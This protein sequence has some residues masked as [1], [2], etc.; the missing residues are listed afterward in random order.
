MPDYAIVCLTR[1]W[2]CQFGQHFDPPQAHTWMDP[3]DAE[4]A[5]HPWPLPADVADA[6]RCA[7]RCAEGPG[8]CHVTVRK[9]P[10]A[11]DA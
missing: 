3:E 9:P 5:G 11:A 1:C 6:N 8:G 4:H 10:E 2:A 7:C